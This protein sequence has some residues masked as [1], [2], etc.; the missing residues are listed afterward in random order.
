MQSLI[1]NALSDALKRP[2][3]HW[4]HD[5]PNEYDPASHTLRQ[6]SGERAPTVSVMAPL[7]HEKHV[8]RPVRFANFPMS[9]SSQLADEMAPSSALALPSAHCVQADSELPPVAVL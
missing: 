9:Q 3:G 8:E 5:D 7:V 1:E 4:T 6:S 2:R